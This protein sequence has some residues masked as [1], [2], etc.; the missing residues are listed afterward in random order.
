MTAKITG[1][2]L[3]GDIRYEYSGTPSKI[4]HCH[5][6][7]CRRHASSPITTFVCVA[8]ENFRYTSGTPV[9][10]ASS[11]GVTR[12]HCGRCG[13][14]I[15]YASSRSSQ[16]DLYIGT[17]DDPAAAVPTY[18]V[19]VAEQLPWFETADALPRYEREKTG[20]AP[21]RHGPRG[22]AEG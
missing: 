19:H 15:S 3:C 13:S 7:S 22:A 10:Y 18:H 14:P 6:E 16:V 17:L 2:C 5:C 8:G 9:A 4:L 11:P 20:N 1:R 21:V 12:T